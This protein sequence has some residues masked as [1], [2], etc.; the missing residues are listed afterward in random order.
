MT[1]PVIS[2]QVAMDIAL[3]WRE[4]EAAEELLKEV[5]QERVRHR[6][7]DIRD[8]FGRRQ[9]G[10]QLG[11]PSG[12]NSHRLFGVPWEMCAPIIEAHIA[13][14][15][16]KIALLSRQALIEA[17]GQADVAVEPAP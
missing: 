3:A 1:T 6:D 16:Q 12:Q 13:R 8:A 9:D 4:I 17:A 5:S 11:V 10:L 15:R 14:K 7:V 2:K